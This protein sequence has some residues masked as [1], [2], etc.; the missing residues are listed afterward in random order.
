MNQT[1]PLAKG[2]VVI[3]KDEERDR[4]KWK[5][6]IVEDLISGR[7]ELPNLEWERNTRTGG[8]T[9]LPTRAVMRLGECTGS[10]ATQ[11]RSPNIRAQEEK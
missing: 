9:P 10:S 4:N 3:I 11:P 1:T 2:E 7:D 6:G 5:I 8:T